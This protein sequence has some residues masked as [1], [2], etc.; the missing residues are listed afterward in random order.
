VL[1][2]NTAGEAAPVRGSLLHYIWPQL[3]ETGTQL[4]LL[5]FEQL[6]GAL[7]ANDSGISVRSTARAEHGIRRFAEPLV[8]E[9]WELALWSDRPATADA[10][11]EPASADDE[12]DT[13]SAVAAA[14]G[15][16]IHRA[17]ETVIAQPRI[18]DTEE[19]RTNLRNH[20]RQQLAVHMSAPSALDEAVCQVEETV[21]RC[22]NDA[23]CA[24]V[25]DGN[26]R[27]S[28]TELAISRTAGGRLFNAVVDRTFVDEHDVRWVI[29]YKTA[30]PEPGVPPERFIAQQVALHRPQLTRYRSLF[31]ELENRPVRTALLLTAFPRLVEVN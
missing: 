13:V 15:T 25:L 7:A 28:A 23:A 31:E 18:F 11:Q 30:I 27:D 12:Q 10:G 29:D 20:W 19:V 17:L 14:I 8:R 3:N 2:R 24:W 6:A 1:T 21:M 4:G 22:L 9:P 16:L 26:L 5:P